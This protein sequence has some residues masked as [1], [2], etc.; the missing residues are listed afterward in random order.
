LRATHE[1]VTDDAIWQRIKGAINAGHSARIAVPFIGLDV[2]DWIK[3]VADSW[4]L[5][6]CD[7]KSARAGQVSGKDLL[8]WHKRGVRI[9]NLQALHAKVFA[10]QDAAFIG[11]SNASVT[12]RDRLIEAGVWSTDKALAAKAWAFVEGHCNEEVDER[13]L[14]ELA[15][16][17]R[18]PTQYPLHGD[19]ENGADKLAVGKRASREQDE[20]PLHLIRLYTAKWTEAQ[21]AA[22]DRAEANGRKRLEKDLKAVISS[23]TWPGAPGRFA[24]GDLVLA[25]MTDKAAGQ[26]MVRPWARVVGTQKVRGKDQHAV[27]TAT[28]PAWNEMELPEF[29]NAS[30]GLMENFLKSGGRSRRATT[31]ERATVLR[32]WKQ[33][34][35]KLISTP[36]KKQRA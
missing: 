36:K 13:F 29:I 20:V 19:S 11:S 23:F 7:L 10:F 14:E 32:I 30:D 3:P 25:R 5:T 2:S 15:E 33:N 9:F 28:L 35:A 4:I 34:R 18:P 1:F 12:S 27:S 31:E 21:Q 24:V 22:A 6:R 16:A 26:E 8:V 17:Y